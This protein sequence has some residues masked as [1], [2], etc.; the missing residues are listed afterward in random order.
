MSTFLYNSISPVINIYILRRDYFDGFNILL[1]DEDGLPF[2]LNVAKVQASVWK[3]T[4]SGTVEEITPFNV[5][6]Q[7]PLRNG[8]A[9]LWLTA[10]QT[11]MI[12]DASLETT[13][14]SISQSFF[15][16]AYSVENN[17]D[18]IASAP[19]VWDVRVQKQEEVG[20]LVSANGGS[21]ITQTSHGLGATD[22]LAFV[23]TS[24]SSI[25]YDGTAPIYSNLTSITY[26][27]P[28]SFTVPVLSGIT[29][30][31]IGGSVYR[32]KQDTVAAGTVF[33]GATFTNFTS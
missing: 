4:A 13:S 33:V 24:E 22:D 29:N 18:T 14:S 10:E 31:A 1:Q 19:I 12:W 23:G 2:D 7:E 21:F 8:Q 16:N 32:L 11:K 6:E 20:I 3:R 27:P 28:Y 15:P 26:V 9:R 5:Q 17:Q 30:A 25:N